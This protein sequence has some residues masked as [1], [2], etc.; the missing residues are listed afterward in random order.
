VYCILS[1]CTSVSP[2]PASNLTDDR[3]HEIVHSAVYCQ[4][5]GLHVLLSMNIG[6]FV[7]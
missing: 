4:L 7:G 3:N 6:S 5:S 1:V 2:A